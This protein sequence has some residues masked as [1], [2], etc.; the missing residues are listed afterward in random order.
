ML[1]I[2]LPAAR[3]KAPNAYF[4]GTLNYYL[5][6]LPKAALEFFK[7]T[8]LLYISASDSKAHVDL[9]YV[10]RCMSVF[11]DLCT[12]VIVFLAIEQA[13]QTSTRRC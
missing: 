5:W 10:C 9:L 2:N 12:F 4:E 3:I 11:F 8:G 7:R 1:D 6:A 13:P